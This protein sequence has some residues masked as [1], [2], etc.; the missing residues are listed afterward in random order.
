MKMIKLLAEFALVTLILPILDYIIGFVVSAI[1]ANKSEK[2][3]WL[4]GS[5]HN[6]HGKV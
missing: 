2:P 4:I 1:V 5:A 6:I 3:T